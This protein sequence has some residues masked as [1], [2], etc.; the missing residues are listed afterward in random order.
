MTIPRSSGLA[1][2]GLMILLKLVMFVTFPSGRAEPSV[3]ADVDGDEG[4]DPVIEF[5]VSTRLTDNLPDKVGVIGRI[6]G[7]SLAGLLDGAVV[8]IPG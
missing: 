4:G 6:N 2:C 3:D 5:I 7:P 1:F 8:T